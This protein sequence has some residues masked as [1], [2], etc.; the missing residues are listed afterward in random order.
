M[1]TKFFDN[2]NYKKHNYYRPS[3]KEET[4]TTTTTGLPKLP[5]DVWLS[6]QTPEKQIE[7]AMRKA[8]RE[9]DKKTTKKTTK[10]KTKA[11]AKYKRRYTRGGGRGG[12]GGGNNIIYPNIVGRGSYYLGG[13]IGYDPN[14]G[15]W[16]GHANGHITDVAGLGDYAV[17]RNSLMSTCIDVGT[18][19]PRV[20]N[21]KKGEATVFQHREYLGDL[22]SGYVPEG[23]SASNYTIQPFIINPG[24]ETLF[25]LLEPIASQF[26]E[27][28]LRGAIVELK[29]LCGEFATNTSLGSVFVGTQYN[30]LEAAPANKLELENLEYSTSCKPSVNLIHCIECSPVNDVMTH[31]YVAPNNVYPEDCD[32]RFYDLGTIY[33]GTQGIPVAYAPIAEIWITYEV[34]LF[35][36]QLNELDTGYG[37]DS[38]IFT[39]AVPGGSSQPPSTGTITADESNNPN[40]TFDGH[41]LS[42]PPVPGQ[43]WFVAYLQGFIGAAASTG[44]PGI[45]YNNNVSLI[46]SSFFPAASTYN[47]SM[48]FDSSGAGG[49]VYA[50][51]TL[52]ICVVDTGG[53]DSELPNL[54][55]GTQTNPQTGKGTLIV[56]QMTL[57]Q[58]EIDGLLANSISSDSK[59]KKKNKKK[60]YIAQCVVR[61]TKDIKRRIIKDNQKL[62][63]ISSY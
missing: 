4:M 36:P 46:S 3:K 23:E 6:Q 13:G 33:I 15:G 5:L 28:E 27:W 16:Y 21:S 24:N 42:L 62:P 48:D 49:L 63:S 29:S 25:P 44:A 32:L 30:V 9:A 1:T 2:P 12:G 17:K 61:D 56:T 8:K 39:F 22:Y 50:N 47:T 20:V 40:I 35:K 37:Q 10:T 57:P 51:A 11:K 31:L 7:W 41:I 18:S 34:A 43:C 26:Q 54:T 59:R 55:I 53:D 19:P 60:K 58:S 38:A 14:N 52:F 45:T